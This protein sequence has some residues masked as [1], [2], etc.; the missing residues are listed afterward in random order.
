LER[1][2]EELRLEAT[3]HPFRAEELALEQPGAFS[4]VTARALSALPSLV[5]LAAPLLAH[6]GL[7]VCF[8][9]RPE[10]DELRRGDIAAQRCGLE[11]IEAVSVHVPGVDAA[12]TIVVYR[13]ESRPSVR[14]PRR[15]GLA[16][17]Q[18]LA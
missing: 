4:A 5:E 1:V 12:R 15:N 3:V 9:G 11:R 2:V 14:L 17:R 8:K 7:L 13:Q 6:K 18:P 16:Q 10:E